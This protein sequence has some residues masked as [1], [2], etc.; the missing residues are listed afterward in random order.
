M[1]KSSLDSYL[2]YKAK[3]GFY[4]SGSSRGVLYGLVYEAVNNTG[5]LCRYGALVDELCGLKNGANGRIDHEVKG[6][7]DI[8][9]SW[10]LSYWFLKLGY[11]KSLYNMPS[12]GSLIQLRTLAESKSAVKYTPEQLNEFI[13]IREK[14]SELT[15]RLLNCDSDML[16]PRIES[17]IRKLGNKLPSEMKRLITIDEVIDKA[18]EDRVKR[19]LERKQRAFA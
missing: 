13:S 10:L 8:V 7:D 1:Q 6:H 16:A 9:I 15:K 18:K 2:R 19:K 11:N 14:I 3:F 5:A 12:G 17:D 4:T